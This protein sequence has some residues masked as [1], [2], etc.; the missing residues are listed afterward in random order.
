MGPH[1]EIQLELATLQANVR[2]AL[3]DLVLQPEDEAELLR[4]LRECSR[5]V[6][7]PV[8]EEVEPP[9]PF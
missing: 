7:V 2:K 4:M 9:L 3:R 6:T 5:F 1:V 8:P